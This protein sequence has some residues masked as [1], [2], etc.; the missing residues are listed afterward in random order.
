MNKN[1][2]SLAIAASVAGT[3]ATMVQAQ[4][5]YVSPDKT[6][7]VILFPFYNAENGNTSAFHIVNT[8]ADAKAI[9]VRFLEYVNSYEVLDFNLYLSP[10]DHFAFGVINH[11][12]GGAI[13]TSDNSCTVPALGSPNGDYSGTQT[14]NAD[15]SITRVQPFVDYLYGEYDAYAPLSRTLTGHIEI[16]EMGTLV[17]DDGDATKKTDLYKAFV[18]HGATGV[19]ANCAALEASWAYGTW[20]G[21]EDVGLRAPSGGLYGLSYLLNVEDS[22]A[23]GFEPDA[24]DNFWYYEEDTFNAHTSP[25]TAAPSIADGDVYAWFTTGDAFY[26][27][28]SE[29]F[30]S[31]AEAVSALF[32]TT[33]IMNDVIVDADI[34]AQTDWVVTFPTKRF[35]VDI[36]PYTGNS[37]VV[38][39]FTD[40]YYPYY[41]YEP[42]NAYID[43]LACETVKIVQWDRE[44]KTAVPGNGFSPAPE[45]AKDKLC[46][47]TQIISH[48]GAGSA[49]NTDEANI[50]LSFP[51]DAGWQKISFNSA[52]EHYMLNADEDVAVYG[53]PAVG[54]AAVKYSND[55]VVGGAI[56]NYGHAAEHKTESMASALTVE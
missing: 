19:P 11:D 35:H 39:P 2:L 15:G 4:S 42:Y 9:K 1:L 34:G 45:E 46:Y 24:I 40:Y 50:A 28:V 37:S 31:G 52:G 22:A 7:E 54:F 14:E 41:Y 38:P 48:G 36:G 16:I 55:S 6:G 26:P 53:L 43:L 32:Q 30:N 8:T 20:S 18:T 44:E 13:I 23:F 25:G 12:G 21:D 47:E 56:A 10:Y 17:N 27:W 51:Y 5:M 33:A 49:M 29:A 3:S